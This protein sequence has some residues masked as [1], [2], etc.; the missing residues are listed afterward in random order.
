MERGAAAV[1]ATA[2]I[3]LKHFL[4]KS[5]LAQKVRIQP[6]NKILQKL[7]QNSIKSV[8]FSGA[9]LAAGL[10][11]TYTFYDYFKKR[12]E[13]KEEK[14]GLDRLQLQLKKDEE[15]K[16]QNFL[17][18]DKKCCLLMESRIFYS[19]FWPHVEEDNQIIILIKKF[20]NQKN[21]KQHI[22]L[23]PEMTLA[24][25]GNTTDQEK[26]NNQFFKNSIPSAALYIIKN[27][28]EFQTSIIDLLN[29]NSQEVSPYDL[30][31]FTEKNVTNRSFYCLVPLH[32]KNNKI[33]INL[34]NEKL[35]STEILDF[36]P[37]II[38]QNAHHPV[39]EEPKIVIS[40]GL[41]IK[42][43]ESLILE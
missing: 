15:E 36:Y 35:M 10:Y 33:L 24:C 43:V 4:E 5:N 7:E 1:G 27:E 21:K 42:E 12:K 25:L 13:E 14:D 26:K 8:G 3:G 20:F 22:I 11:G 29:K 17:K 39:L 9:L 2:T 19:F 16:Y 6:F 31:Q 37:D 23:T 41:G 28:N 30:Y 32:F 38:N 40:K 18:S 34:N